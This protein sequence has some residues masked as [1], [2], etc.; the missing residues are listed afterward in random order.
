MSRTASKKDAGTIASIVPDVPK[1][2][3]VSFATGARCIATVPLS[4]T[5]D[6]GTVISVCDDDGTVVTVDLYWPDH[7]AVIRPRLLFRNALARLQNLAEMTSDDDR[8]DAEL[9]S[10]AALTTYMA[11]A[12]CGWNVRGVECTEAA[13]R[14]LFVRTPVTRQ[15]IAVALGESDNFLPESLK[16]SEGES[17]PHS[18]AVVK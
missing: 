13:A 4:Q 9:L 18:V 16:H 7:P 8:V 12:V 17:P 15:I 6:D 1:A 2:V 5:G 10:D 3:R 14:E 11:L